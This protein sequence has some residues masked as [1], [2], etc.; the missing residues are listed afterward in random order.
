MERNN[1]NIFFY[2][3]QVYPPKQSKK[4]AKVRTPVDKEKLILQP[5]QEE[6]FVP[7]S[8]PPVKELRD[9]IL[10]ENVK[11]LEQDIQLLS[12]NSDRDFPAL[13]SSPTERTHNQHAQGS[14]QM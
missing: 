13:N 5:I 4:A 6:K 3:L 9:N 7:L 11:Q 1:F 14:R 8:I 2:K 12:T 10:K